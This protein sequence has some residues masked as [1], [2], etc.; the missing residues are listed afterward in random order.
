MFKFWDNV[1]VTTKTLNLILLTATTLFAA[2]MFYLWIS[3]V[4]RIEEVNVLFDYLQIQW[5]K[6]EKKFPILKKIRKF[7]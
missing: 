5:I 6:G 4:M 1:L 7:I 2:M 3:Y